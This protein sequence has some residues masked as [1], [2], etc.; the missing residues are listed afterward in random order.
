M[1]IDIIFPDPKGLLAVVELI[2]KIVN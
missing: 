2:Q 1:I